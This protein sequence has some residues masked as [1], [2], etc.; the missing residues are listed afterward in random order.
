MHRFATAL[1]CLLALASLPTAFAPAHASGPPPS[2]TPREASLV[3]VPGAMPRDSLSSSVGPSSFAYDWSTGYASLSGGGHLSGCDTLTVL[4]LPAG[5]PVDLRFRLHVTAF[6][7]TSLVPSPGFDYELWWFTLGE[8]LEFTDGI[9]P[10]G[11]A[12]H[13]DGVQE[14]V[15]HRTAG[16]PFPMRWQFNGGAPV[17]HVIQVRGTWEVLDLPE[18]ATLLSRAGYGEAPVP[19]RPSTWGRI[20]LIAR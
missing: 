9:F 4:G 11:P 3:G 2:C 19:A 18:G 7:D 16:E 1:A 20:K 14:I 15:I 12:I 13:I 6:I 5:T 10:G 17:G 8:A